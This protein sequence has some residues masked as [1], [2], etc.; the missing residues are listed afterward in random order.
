M[1]ALYMSI[2]SHVQ[3]SAGTCKSNNI[4][5][6]YEH[7]GIHSDGVHNLDCFGKYGN[8]N[9]CT[10]ETGK[11]G[12]NK[13]YTLILQQPD[14][15]YCYVDY[16]IEGFYKKIKLFS[17]HNFTV[18]VFE[19]S[20]TTNCT[21]AV[22]RGS[23]KT[24]PRC[25]PPK[26]VLLSRPPGELQVNV[27]WHKEDVKYI[28]KFSVR[29]KVLSSHSWKKPVESQYPNAVRLEK[30]N[31]SLVYVVQI[32]CVTSDKCSQCPWSKNY[33]VP[34]E[35]KT[36][37]IISSKY[38]DIKEI[39][40]HRLF[41]ITWKF[42][43]KE[44][45]DGYHVTV[46]K[47]SGEPPQDQ[48]TTSKPEIKLVL[49]YSAYQ[50]NIRAFNN[51]SFSSA[52]THIIPQYED[53][54]DSGDRRLNVTVHNSTAFT[55][56][57][58]TDLIRMYVC[59]SVEWMEKGH[60]AH[61]RSFFEDSNSN[62]T[63]SSLS[64][65][66]EPFKRYSV[67]LHLRPNKNTCNMKHI[68]NS[69]STYGT[70]EF[71]YIEGSPVSSSANISFHNVT[72]NSV[73]LQWSKIQEEDLRGFLLGYIIHYIEYHYR[74]TITEHNITVDPGF[75]SF[76]M[77]N[78]K[79]GTAYQVQISAF[80]SAG[81]GIRSVPSVFKTNHKVTFSISGAI[82]AL[83]FVTFL[84]LCGSPVIKRAKA[85]LWPSIPNPGHSNAVQIIESPSQ[86]ELLVALATLKVEEWDTKSLQLLEKEAV[87]PLASVLPLLR[88]C[89][90]VRDSP[91]NTH[92]WSERDTDSAT[93]DNL[94][95]DTLQDT[96]STHFQSSPLPFAGGYTTM[97]M[98]QQLIPQGMAADSSNTPSIESTPEDLTM[99]KSMK[100]DYMR[101]FSSSP[102]SDNEHTST[103]L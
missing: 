70:T 28:S 2:S 43:V 84:L 30:L 62:K 48:M 1:L 20:E 42:P 66:L 96:R 10:W 38:L 8:S 92:T 57:W 83:I 27:S 74:E 54:K 97:E 89:E 9:K 67:T 77:E 49:S 18:E 14:K 4:S 44:Q 32:Q 76:H 15:P 102:P 13:S 59:Y 51:V 88:N 56:Y 35:L 12:S 95:D 53:T 3:V 61:Y 58:R 26:G 78:L 100:L 6:K 68:N 63:L 86:L 91:E 7:C 94:H 23:P 69:E 31:S 46:W 65:P 24:M 16:N 11:L 80:T 99:L 5:G 29:Y 75:T 45:C 40:G 39:T 47:E 19:N 17:Q 81:A 101:Q 103:I 79:S 36:Q 60:S 52:V 93:E 87:I 85:I 22:F 98:L 64:E 73:V 37:P 21:K 71:Y 33:T 72:V 82:T 25:D 34:S 90:D 41:S 50:L 55:I